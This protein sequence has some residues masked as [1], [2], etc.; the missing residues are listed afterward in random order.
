MWYVRPAKAHISLHILYVQSDQSLCLSLEYS[1]SVKLLTEHRFRV[2][3][4]KGNCTGLSETT[5]VK[6]VNLSFVEC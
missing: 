2:L 1:R 6:I 4:L 5:L 3:G